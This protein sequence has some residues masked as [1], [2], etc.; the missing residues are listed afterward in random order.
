MLGVQSR[1][2]TINALLNVLDTPA[3]LLYQHPAQAVDNKIVRKD[4]ELQ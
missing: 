1:S 3:D 4:R 2:L